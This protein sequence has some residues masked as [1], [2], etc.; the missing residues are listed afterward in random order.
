MNPLR[1]AV[2]IGGIF[3][4]LLALF[5]IFLCYQIFKFY[6]SKPF[7][8]LMEMM[9]IGGTI[10]IFFLAVTSLFCAKALTE[11]PLGRLV[12]LL[13]I[14]IYLARTLGELMLFPKPS[15]LIV[16]LCAFLALLYAYIYVEGGKGAARHLTRL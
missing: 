4:S 12:V 3:N 7:F 11:T 16:G 10:L 6:G 14:S 15:S 1:A 9:S 2:L 13:N 5:H 8:P